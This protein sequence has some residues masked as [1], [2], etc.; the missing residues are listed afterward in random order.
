MSFE[1]IYEAAIGVTALLVSIFFL[2][3]LNSNEGWKNEKIAY[4]FTAALTLMSVYMMTQVL[5]DTWR[6]FTW[7]G[8]TFPS[9]Q[10]V[11]EGVIIGF[12]ASGLWDIWTHDLD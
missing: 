9:L 7:Q 3:V 4:K 12:M 11:F 8:I 1:I 6:V 10:I 5:E 2:V